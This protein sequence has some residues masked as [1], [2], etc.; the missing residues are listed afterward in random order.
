MGI[1]DRTIALI[2]N[3]KF[4]ILQNKKIIVFGCGGVGGYVIEMLARSG[5]K[6]LTIVDF[7]VVSESNINRQII[8]TT[9]TIG[10]LKTECFKNR[11]QLINSDCNVTCINKKLLAENIGEFNLNSY[12]FVVDCI[13]M[14]TSKVALIKFCFENNIQIISSMGTGNKYDIPN[15]EICDIYQ[16]KNDGLAR[17]MRQLLKKAGV[18]NATVIYS[19]QDSKKQDIIGSIAYFPAMCGIMISAYIINKFIKEKWYEHRTFNRTKFFR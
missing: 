18:K 2:G 5:I 9:N 7:D 14:V 12:D 4:D 3:E 11:I 8:A 1:H 10:L 19:S 17:V 15:F 6:N 16:T 13:D